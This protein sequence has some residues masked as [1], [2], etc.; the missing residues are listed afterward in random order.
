MI[1]PTVDS[2]RV[3]KLFSSQYLSRRGF[4][5][6]FPILGCFS[7]NQHPISFLAFSHVF[8]CRQSQTLKVEIREIYS[9]SL[10]STFS[11]LR[12]S[13]CIKGQPSS[14]TEIYHNAGIHYSAL[15]CPFSASNQNHSKVL[16]WHLTELV[17]P[18][19]L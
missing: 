13:V 18:V 7:V 10:L 4:I 1:F 12:S 11:H 8:R 6:S 14:P 19:D 3:F 9:Y 16:L 17:H 2:E 5:L 15:P